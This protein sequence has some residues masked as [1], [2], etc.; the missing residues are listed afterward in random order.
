MRTKKE[1]ITTAAG[2][3]VSGTPSDV[4]AE[5]Q[6]R[7]EQDAVELGGDGDALLTREQAAQLLG[8]KPATLADWACHGQ[9]FPMLK[10]GRLVRYRL[11]DLRQYLSAREVTSTATFGRCG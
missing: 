2:P 5:A 3:T 7:G 4:R 1:T 8:C 6:G 9:P 11:S 10:V